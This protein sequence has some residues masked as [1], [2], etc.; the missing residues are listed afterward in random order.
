MQILKF[1]DLDEVIHRANETEYGLGAGIMTQNLDKANY[2]SQGIRA[3]SV[4]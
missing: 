2:L 3:G 1:S 4:W